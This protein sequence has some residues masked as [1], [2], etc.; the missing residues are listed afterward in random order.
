MTVG[1]PAVD[2]EERLNYER[3]RQERLAKAKEQLKAHGR[4]ALLCYDFYNIRY[5]TGT[6]L[7]EWARNKTIR[8][9]ILPKDAA[10]IFYDPVAPARRKTAQP[11]QRSLFASTTSF[12]PCLYYAV[13]SMIWIVTVFSESLLGYVSLKV[14]DKTT[15]P[16]TS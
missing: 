10:P 15:F 4:G 13:E 9:V 2:F 11:C 16:R 12:A 1:T 3:L 5:I 7:G 14:I 8:Y 6:H